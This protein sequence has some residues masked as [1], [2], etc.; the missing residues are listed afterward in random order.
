MSTTQRNYVVL[1]TVKLL[2]N[3]VQWQLHRTKLESCEHVHLADQC[4]L[5]CSSQTGL[6]ELTASEV[7][8]H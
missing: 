5:Y 7:A 6:I 8:I 2:I 4:K 3:P 1:C